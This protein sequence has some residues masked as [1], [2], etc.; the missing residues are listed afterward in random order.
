MAAIFIGIILV[1]IG[2]FMPWA[3]ET[4]TMGVGPMSTGNISKS[5]TGYELNQG[6]IGAGI[7]VV[8]AI[9][10]FLS[11]RVISRRVVGFLIIVASIA[12]IVICGNLILSP[13]S[14]NFSNGDIHAMSHVK[15]KMGLYITVI[16]GIVLLIGGL[17]AAF[18]SDD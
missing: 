1:V 3:N 16:G 8:S 2:V 14:S 5:V 4:I 12:I 11:G 10:G 15:L 9:L 18:R 13:S 7:A 6:L 17:I